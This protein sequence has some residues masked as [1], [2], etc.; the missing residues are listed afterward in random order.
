MFKYHEHKLLSER[1]HALRKRH[2][3]D[4]QLTMVINDNILDN[5]EQVDTFILDF[6]KALVNPLKVY[7]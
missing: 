1:Q 7:C 6:E 4:T 2:S 5:K 3:C